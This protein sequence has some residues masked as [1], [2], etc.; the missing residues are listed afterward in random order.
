[1]LLP[2]SGAGALDGVV[3]V[4]QPTPCCFW[5]V[6][7]PQLVEASFVVLCEPKAFEQRPIFEDLQRGRVMEDPLV[8]HASVELCTATL[9]TSR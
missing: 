5:K 9:A 3:G 1:M 2:C 6:G 7:A 8:L 4:R